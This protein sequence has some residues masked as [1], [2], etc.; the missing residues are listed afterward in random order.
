[1]ERGGTT[2]AEAEPDKAAQAST[3]RGSTTP[4]KAEHDSAAHTTTERD[5][6]AHTTTERDSTGQ[7]DAERGKTA[8]ADAERGS[9]ERGSAAQ[10]D[11]DVQHAHPDAERAGKELKGAEVEGA[12]P[13]GAPQAAADG[14]PA[15]KSPAKDSG[16]ER[17]GAAERPE[18]A[19]RA[20]DPGNPAE[21]AKAQSGKPAE[22]GADSLFGAA[23]QAAPEEK[24]KRINGESLRPEPQRPEPGP[25]LPVRQGKTGLNGSGFGNAGPGNQ[26]SGN[27]GVP[28]QGGP[29][30][31]QPGGLGAASM[32]PGVPGVQI[33]PLPP[34]PAPT[35]GTVR[36]SLFEPVE[37][38][39]DVDLHALIET[40][41]ANLDDTTWAVAQNRVFTDSPGAVDELAKL[42][43]VSPAEIEE[44]ETDLRVRMKKWLVSDDARPYRSHLG[45]LQQT[46]GKAAPKARLVGAADWHAR[47]IRVL[48]VPAWQFVLAS[49]PGYRLVDDWVVDGDL[50]DLQDKTRH[51]IIGAER[52]PTVGRALELVSTLG[53]HPEV[54][55]E[56]LENVPQLRILTSREGKSRR[57]EPDAGAAATGKTAERGSSTDTDPRGIRTAGKDDPPAKE[58]KSNGDG[59]KAS[60]KRDGDDQAAI[61]DDAEPAGTDQDKSLQDGPDQSK[62]GEDAPTGTDDGG[63]EGEAA[64][65]AEGTGK[66]TTGEHSAKQ[67]RPLKDV[68]HTRRCFR[69]PD[70]RWWLRVD[71]TEEHLEGA[72]C[73]LPSGFAAYLG[74]A[75]GQSRTVRSAAG[76]LTMTWQSRPVVE[77]LKQLLDGVN[78]KEGGHLFLTLSEEGVLR[79][80]HLPAAGP[81]VDPIVR[82]L[83]LV[84]YTAPG[85]TP[86]QAA[87]VI[88]TR[89][90]MP[91]NP[92]GQPDL[93]VRLRE[94]GDRDLLS[95]LA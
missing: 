79:A 66:A 9:A 37:P 80:R 67:F 63:G 71:I 94:R 82:A 51:L 24:N 84:G 70:G 29:V 20:E 90:G 48:E 88:S 44:I 13:Q 8:G 41:F 27:Q 5:S 32:V 72:E 81:D 43:A 86:E 36:R 52:P 47:E 28:R 54:A 18:K 89:I 49:L 34:V 77:S 38:Q 46:L 74:L 45:R 11:S 15:R 87:R 91:T 6:A 23:A 7:S 2:Q 1:L 3:E 35:P 76:E 40:S 39:G 31:G 78:A 56:W 10:A 50:S 4:A 55:K 26:R 85:G 42:F 16:P 92:A 21:E 73:A 58:D 83:R 53:I 17:P 33:P 59:K 14:N 95:L 57:A 61:K 93:L 19:K 62:T 60:G 75:P 68:S 30:P 69:Q 64:E 22:P 12:E 25:G 65:E